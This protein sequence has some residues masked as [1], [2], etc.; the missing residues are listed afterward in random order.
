MRRETTDW[1]KIFA[2][3]TSNKLLTVKGHLRSKMYK[4]FLKFNNK[5]SNNPIKNGPKTFTDTLA[6]NIYRWY[7]HT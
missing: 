5:K 7:T 4:E 2:K 6:K 3:D 1:Q